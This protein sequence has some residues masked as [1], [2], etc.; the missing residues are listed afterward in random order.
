M[1]QLAQLWLP[2]IVA[3][4]VV[5]FVSFLIWMVLPHHKKD[6]LP[7]PDEKAFTDTISATNLSPGLYMWPHNCTADGKPVDDAQAR[8][9]AGP[10]GSINIIGKSPNFGMNLLLTFIFYIVVSVFVAYLTMQARPFGSGFLPVFQVAGT[11]AILGYAAG[12][13]P[14]AIFFG[15][16]TRFRMTELMD[17][18]AYGLLTGAVFAWLWPG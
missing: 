7:L 14:H 17:H 18:L 9:A 13:V 4:I 12:G 1:E 5:F 8:Y 2:I 6:I 11:A 3:S 16:P 15:I 10:W